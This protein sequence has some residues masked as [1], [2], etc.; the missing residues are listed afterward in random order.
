MF[1]CRWVVGRVEAS[2]WEGDFV[3]T[4]TQMLRRSAPFKNEDFERLAR[5]STMRRRRRKVPARI[6]RG[7]RGI[8]ILG[9][10][11]QVV[12][13]K[14]GTIIAEPLVEC[15]YCYMLLTLPLLWIYHRNRY[16]VAEMNVKLTRISGMWNDTP[17]GKELGGRVSPMNTKNI[18]NAMLHVICKFYNNVCS[19]RG[20]VLVMWK[21][22][23]YPFFV[24]QPVY[25]FMFF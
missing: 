1:S 13:Q 2:K 7:E 3:F 12:I 25:L 20:K 8:K 11:K 19:K 10:R 21:N 15:V 17:V 4:G 5:C 23:Y 9:A 14:K 18:T 24:K 16:L 6:R 22:R